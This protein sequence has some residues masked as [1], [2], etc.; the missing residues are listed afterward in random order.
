MLT[1]S[2]PRSC[3]PPEGTGKTSCPGANG[4][5]G[6]GVG[7]GLV[8]GMVTATHLNPSMAV[9]AGSN[10]Y[11]T[12]AQ[13]KAAEAPAEDEKTARNLPQKMEQ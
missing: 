4:G 2:E 5:S 1:S 3:T 10:P 13:A 12:G 11:A 8:Q 9:G 6:G 7:G